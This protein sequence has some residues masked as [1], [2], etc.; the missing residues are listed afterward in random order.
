MS[1]LDDFRSMTHEISAAYDIRAGEL[2]SIKRHIR[3]MLG[4]LR[5]TRREESR[6]LAAERRKEVAHIKKQVEG[7][8]KET[9]NSLR[10][11]RKTTLSGI[12][13]ETE[14]RKGEVIDMLGSF[15]KDFIDGFRKE[16][17]GMTSAWGD[18]VQGLRAK[19]NQVRTG[20]NL[21]E[22]KSGKRKRHVANRAA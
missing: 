18:L 1:I 22:A 17:E 12:K 14:D 5:R 8:K 3:T 6:K 16:M 19:R 13:M 21:P 11:F 7:I 4:D 20:Q 9:A 15:R 10:D 2:A